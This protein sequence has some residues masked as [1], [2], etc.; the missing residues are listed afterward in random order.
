MAV[1]F[2]THFPTEVPVKQAYRGFKSGDR[3]RAEVVH[4]RVRCLAVT[5][6][7]GRFHQSI[8]TSGSQT[9][10]ARGPRAKTHLIFSHR[11]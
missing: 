11:P 3:L 7:L 10:I 1:L 8:R 4:T 6:R 9:F 5:W 2:L